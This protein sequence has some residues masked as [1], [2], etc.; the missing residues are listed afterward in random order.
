[1]PEVAGDAAILVSPNNIQEIAQAMSKLQTDD[2]YWENLA[3]LSLNR[4][5]AFN[6]DVSAAKLWECM[7]KSLG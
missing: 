6:W 3:T 2:E 1:M 7:L 5:K 4:S